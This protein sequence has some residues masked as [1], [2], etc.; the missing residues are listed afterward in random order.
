MARCT[1]DQFKERANKTMEKHSHFS[2][3]LGYEIGDDYTIK[4]HM[5]IAPER[6]KTVEILEPAKTITWEYY[7]DKDGFLQKK[8]DDLAALEAQILKRV[9]I[10]ESNI[11]SQLS[12]KMWDCREYDIEKDEPNKKPAAPLCST[13]TDT[14]SDTQK[15]QF[16]RICLADRLTEDQITELL[17]EYEGL[18]KISCVV[19]DRIEQKRI[20]RIHDGK[21]TCQVDKNNPPK[22]C[23]LEETR[24]FI[25]NW[26]ME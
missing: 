22:E 25:R 24:A 18:E 21:L 23:S 12:L 6:R 3:L 17:K 7:L 10:E 5:Q 19:P 16:P 4:I 26:I 1:I 2:Q 8:S 15:E 14:A 11:F 20:Y 13:S 9:G